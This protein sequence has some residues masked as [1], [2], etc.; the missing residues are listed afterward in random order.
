MTRPDRKL[1]RLCDFDYSQD[2]LYFVTSCVKD[3]IC[4]F[5][6]VVDEEMQ[7]NEHGHIAERQWYWLA[8]QYPYVILHAFVVMPNHMHG[9]IEIDRENSPVGTGR[10]LSNRA[11]IT[12]HEKTTTGALPTQKIKSLSALMGVYKTTTSKLVR[13]AG[14]PD[15][16]WQRSFHDHI[17]R[18][19]SAYIHIRNYIQENPAKWQHDMF[20][21]PEKQRRHGKL[22]PS[23]G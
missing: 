6:E 5:G 12:N 20:Y 22:K 17:I 9:I 7:V 15:F 3:K 18:H 16:A 14:L 21:L 23:S 13:L 8:E 1:N 2:A 4:V 10:D 19:N 11:P